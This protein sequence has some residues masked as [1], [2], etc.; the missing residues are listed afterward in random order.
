MVLKQPFV[1]KVTANNVLNW[2]Q[3]ATS[4]SERNR[5]LK[6]TCN[7]F[8]ETHEPVNFPPWILLLAELHPYSDQPWLILQVDS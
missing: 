3:I 2:V 1:A 6:F 5:R 8:K 4:R 7:K